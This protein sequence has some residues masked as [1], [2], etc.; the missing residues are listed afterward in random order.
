MKQSE[1]SQ[2]CS[3][4]HD[5]YKLTCVSYLGVFEFEKSLKVF[6]KIWLISDQGLHNKDTQTIDKRNVLN[7]QH[8]HAKNSTDHHTTF[9]ITWGQ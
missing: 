3:G 5:I 6:Y 4:T 2:W 8:Q 1:F 9:R 7:L